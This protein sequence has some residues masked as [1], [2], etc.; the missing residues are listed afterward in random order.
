VL[1][2]SPLQAGLLWTV[3]SAGGLIVGSMLPPLVV[4]R[5]SP[6]AASAGG[7]AVAAVGFGLLTQVDDT[8]GLTILVIGS[9]VLSLG[10]AAVVPLTTDLIVGSA[11]PEKAG[12]ASG[13]SETG[14]ELGGALGIAVLGSIGTAVYRSEVAVPASVPPDA[15][16][17]ARD[18]LGGAVAAAR[19]LPDPIGVRLLD[20]AREAFAQGLQLTAT[21]CAVLVMGLAIL[22]AV[23]LRNVRPGSEDQTATGR[24]E[25]LRPTSMSR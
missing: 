2:L 3:P 17:A 14:T 22:V 5:V 25:L 24:T 20:A 19:Q 18:T 12:A 21:T 15:A 23:S 10:I 8:S 16:Q 9:V 11:P 1:G 13:I 7:L 4:R 6:A